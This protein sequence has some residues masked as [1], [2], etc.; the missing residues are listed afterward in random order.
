M[1]LPAGSLSL[2]SVGAVALGG[3]VG[4]LAR[5]LITLAATSL[6]G[7]RF[8]WGTLAVNVLGCALA[9]IVLHLAV[10]R[11]TL[12]AQARLLLM[13]GFLGGLTTFSAFAFETL[14]L[15]RAGSVALAASNVV[16]NV[17]LSL[18]AVWCGWRAA[19]A[20]IA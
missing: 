19:G 6:A 2:A 8:P 15:A 5:Y 12:G 13:T 1:D 7:P 14:Q 4:S 9:G 18:A 3:G 20:L 16:G 11:Q 17:A 10:D